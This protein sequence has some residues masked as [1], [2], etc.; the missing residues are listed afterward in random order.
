MSD[1]RHPEREVLIDFVEGEL[2]HE[3]S[4]EVQLHLDRCN[5]CK[6]Y[7]ET[8]KHTYSLMARDAVPE[9]DPGYY[10]YLAQRARQHARSR[11]RRPL[12]ALVP[13]VAAAAIVL[14]VIWWGRGVEVT[15][16]DSIDLLLAGMN[17]GEVVES[18]SGTSTYDELAEVASDEITVVEEFIMATEDVEG[19]LGVLSDDEK[20]DLIS[21]LTRIMGRENGENAS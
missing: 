2:S 18:V 14:A 16:P 7:V 17:T 1:K 5:D 12:W 10:A 9:P 20:N 11:R 3:L 19:L 4:E 8:L 21:E 13:G 6:S 15:E